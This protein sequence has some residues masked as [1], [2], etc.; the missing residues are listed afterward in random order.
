LFNDAEEEGKK[1]K[2]KMLIGAMAAISVA[3]TVRAFAEFQTGGS[4]QQSDT[5]YRWTGSMNSGDALEIKSING[6]IEVG[7]SSGSDVVVV[8]EL[9]G[10]RSDPGTV[11]IEVVEHGGGMTFCAVYPTPEGKE[12]N[13]CGVGSDG[14]MSS[15]RNDVQV[16]FQ[17]LVPEGVD[18]VARTVNGDIEALDLGSDVS[19]NTVNGDIDL[20]TS[21]FAEAETV[22]G[23]IE[24]VMGGRDLR[25]GVAFS[26][27]NGSISL[28][29]DDQIDAD[30]DASWLNGD[31]ESDIPFA[32]DGGMS[33]GKASGVLGD[34]G[35]DL[36]LSTVNGSIRIH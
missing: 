18:F 15:E 24:A 4:E 13:Y 14:R 11:R 27:V 9:S 32:L 36:E 35:A 23:S 17:V 25:N 5:E 2:M 16:E 28:D 3:V 8:A 20:S 29:V 1:M 26:T 19:L 10:R 7:R 22:N 31:F 12:E 6:D 30:L 34:G 33:R 21:G